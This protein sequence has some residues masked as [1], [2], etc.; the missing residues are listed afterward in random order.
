MLVKEASGAGDGAQGTPGGPWGF[1]MRPHPCQGVL[2]V[3]G[4]LREAQLLTG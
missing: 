4:G 2:W 3:P 1:S